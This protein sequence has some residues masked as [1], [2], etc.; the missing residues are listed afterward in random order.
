LLLEVG[1]GGRLDA[2]NVIKS[3]LLAVI[4]SIGMDHMEILGDTIEQIAAEKAGII[5]E[6]CK[7]VLYSNPDL[8]YNIIAEI[9]LAKNTK[10]YAASQI[11]LEIMSQ[12]PVL[13]KFIACGEYFDKIYIELSLAGQHQLENARAV[14]AAICALNDAG[15]AITPAH[16]K[17]G[18]ANVQWFGRMEIAHENPMII[19]EGA[20]NL[21]GATSAA[22]SMSN[23]FKGRQ[24]TLVL[25]ILA[26]KE[27]G[28]IVRTLAAKADKIIFT[29][30]I[31]DFKAATPNDLALAL[32]ETTK[33][34]Y[35]IENC[36]EALQKAIKITNNNN[37]IF[38]SGS[39]YLI[40]DLRMHI[41]EGK[42]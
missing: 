28:D 32:G 14:L 16:I 17:Q 4:M 15:Y 6:N 31:Y 25:G 10:I 19:L 3:P 20:H 26:D 29:K 8:V 24:I 36:H 42:L 41:K 1:I 40:G 30:P 38:C 23:L 21:Q 13:T 11:S 18:L 2:T 9:A 35:V 34:V 33:E 12:S 39:L 5:K 37:V 7:A 22:H 27:Y